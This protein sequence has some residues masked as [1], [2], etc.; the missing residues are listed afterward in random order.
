MVQQR[1]RPVGVHRHVTHQHLLG[2]HLPGRPAVASGPTPAMARSLPAYHALISVIVFVC[3]EICK[4]VPLNS[5]QYASG[6]RSQP[7]SQVRSTPGQA[8]AASCAGSRRVRN[9]RIGQDPQ[10]HTTARTRRWSRSCPHRTGRIDGAADPPHRSAVA[11]SG[12]PAAHCYPVSQAPPQTISDRTVGVLA[13]QPRQ[14]GNAPA[15]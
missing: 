10:G 9:R 4:A 11:R 13:G 6:C 5:G 3:A 8:A 12:G 15:M 2:A 14:S 7:S 1:D